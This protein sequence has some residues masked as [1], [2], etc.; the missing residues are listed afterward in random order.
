MGRKNNL[1]TATAK[2]YE[3][4][5]DVYSSYKTGIKDA[6]DTM[7]LA[8]EELAKWDILGEAIYT[9]LVARDGEF[10][11]KQ[12]LKEA[13]LKNDEYMKI[14]CETWLKAIIP[15]Y[16]DF[17]KENQKWF[18]ETTLN[19]RPVSNFQSLDDYRAERVNIE[20]KYN[21]AMAHLE[22]YVPASILS[23]LADA[24][25]L[26]QSEDEEGSTSHVEKYI[27]T[28]S[29]SPILNNES[30]VLASTRFPELMMERIIKKLDEDPFVSS[31]ALINLFSQNPSKL[32]QEALQRAVRRS[33]EEIVD[34]KEF[35]EWGGPDFDR[36]Y[37]KKVALHYEEKFS[38]RWIVAKE[39]VFGII[40]TY[41]NA[42]ARDID[43]I[44][45]NYG[46]RFGAL[47]TSPLA[48]E[49]RKS[50]IDC[51]EELKVYCSSNNIDINEI[52]PNINKRLTEGYYEH[53]DRLKKPVLSMPDVAFHYDDEEM[54][55]ALDLVAKAKI[56]DIL[57]EYGNGMTIEELQA[58]LDENDEL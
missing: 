44:K 32:N 15:S 4:D 36:E 8:Y 25:A 28:L 27:Q 57:E 2:G 34:D 23:R 6:M 58:F 20:Y 49:L 7:V 24:M 41:I 31:D 30:A 54:L 33:F 47:L 5:E 45:D 43:S 17:I 3:Y 26:D 10:L 38:E 14:K 48:D 9:Y 56:E 11:F 29:A 53:L 40:R 37:F 19:G 1:F 18:D 50:L 55:E 12:A 35:K 13:E 52:R 46:E 39:S 42:N 51:D 21:K 22:K 16:K